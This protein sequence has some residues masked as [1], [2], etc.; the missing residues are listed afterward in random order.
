MLRSALAKEN[1][2]LVS[3]A[4]VKDIRADIKEK[5]RAAL[6]SCDMLITTGGVSVGEYD[7]VKDVLAE[8]GVER[9][10]WG[11]SQ[12]PGGP[13]YFGRREDTLVFGLP[14]NP[15]SSLVCYY[16]YVRPAVRKM[17]GKK[18]IFLKQGSARLLVPIRKK[19]G[20]AHFL[21][22]VVGRDNEGLCV[23][24]A[25]GQG[26]HMLKSFA[27]ANSLIVISEDETY[28]PQGSDV[29]VHYLP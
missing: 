24:A 15:A 16:E 17:A 19:P 21:R 22:G 12:R 6:S 18:D 27:L 5:V 20:K 3:A 28:L 10:F 8:E 2:E 7:F 14:G 4:R 26:S 29:T 23:E 11:V 1:V 25:G 13:M 9:I